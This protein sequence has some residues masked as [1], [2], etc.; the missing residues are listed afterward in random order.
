M[1]NIYS[2]KLYYQRVRAFLRVY[3]PP[4]IRAP[5][6]RQRCFALFRSSIR[7]GVLGAER[8]QYWKTLLWT[9]F[10]RP[11]LVPLAVTLAIYGHHFRKICKV[12]PS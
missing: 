12:L 10:R 4:K 6:D 7:L 11:T 5:L 1:L 2:P 9:S 8:L 3:N